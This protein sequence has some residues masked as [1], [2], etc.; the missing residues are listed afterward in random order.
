MEFMHV[1][2][3]MYG[4][5]NCLWD[6][7]KHIHIGQAYFYSKLHEDNIKKCHTLL[8]SMAHKEKWVKNFKVLIETL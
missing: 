7:N 2:Q 6:Q 5:Y 8:W 1:F 3:A 4:L